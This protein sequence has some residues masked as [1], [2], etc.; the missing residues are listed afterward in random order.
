MI[1]HAL[2]HAGFLSVAPS[3]EGEL[4]WKTR[5]DDLPT[6]ADVA[7]DLGSMT[8][9][10]LMEVTSPRGEVQGA[11]QIAPM[12]PGRDLVVACHFTELFAYSGVGLVW[13]SVRIA[14]DRIRLESASP[15]ELRGSLWDGADWLPFR[16]DVDEWNFREG[17]W[18][19]WTWLQS[20]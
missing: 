17:P 5:A 12:S 2:D 6:I 7:R 3:P 18:Q 1:C 19:T 4:V 13:R 15:E 8:R 16:L 14:L 11:S 20:T 9:V 10:R